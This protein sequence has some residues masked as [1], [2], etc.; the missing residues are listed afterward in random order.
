MGFLLVAL[1]AIA[2]AWQYWPIDVYSHAGEAVPVVRPPSEAEAV[3]I[4]A[5]G[6]YGGLPPGAVRPPMLGIQEVASIDAPA[7]RSRTE[8]YQFEWTSSDGVPTDD[9]LIVWVDD[10]PVAHCIDRF[11]PF[12]STPAI[13]RG[14]SAYSM[15]FKP[16][17]QTI[18]RRWEW[19]PLRFVQQWQIRRATLPAPVPLDMT[20]SCAGKSLDV[21]ALRRVVGATS[22]YTPYHGMGQDADEAFVKLHANSA[23]AHF[24]PFRLSLFPD[25]SDV[26]FLVTDAIVSDDGYRQRPFFLRGAMH[27][28]LQLKK[29]MYIHF[30]TADD[31]PICRQRVPRTA[32]PATP[33][34]QTLAQMSD[35]AV[36]RAQEE[37]DYRFFF[38][39]HH[40]APTVRLT[41]TTSIPT[42]T[43]IDALVT[44]S[45]HAAWHD[46]FHYDS[47]GWLQR[48]D[49]ALASGARAQ[50]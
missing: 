29:P 38:Q 1:S 21:D 40:K 3:A 32:V 4:R 20:N 33:E 14:C 23:L 8:R 34:T 12:A 18:M 26:Y 17:V 39:W 7:P 42:G 25:R 49:F 11:V 50:N 35:D 16:Y 5:L 28:D 15:T 47:R 27:G 31:E 24:K 37:F 9:F 6:F 36:A 44:S 2:I 22:K 45:E 48:A 10:L 43:D 13:R 46:R 19:P 41:G 30:D